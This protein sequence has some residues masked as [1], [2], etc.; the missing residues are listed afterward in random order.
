M[1]TEKEI[2]QKTSIPNHK[3]SARYARSI[4]LASKLELVPSEGDKISTLPLFVRHRSICLSG[5][6]SHKHL[7]IKKNLCRA[8]ARSAEVETLGDKDLNLDKQIQ[9]LLSYH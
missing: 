7:I 6:Y 2:R 8:E 3:I 9:S 4:Y 1:E 5:Y